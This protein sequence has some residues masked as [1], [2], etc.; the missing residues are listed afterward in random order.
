MTATVMLLGFGSLLSAGAITHNL[1]QQAARLGLAQALYTKSLQMN[2]EQI[3]E[4][5]NYP[6]K[7]PS[8]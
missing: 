3:S 6:R 8:K 4:L 7:P 2:R 1:Q 5:V